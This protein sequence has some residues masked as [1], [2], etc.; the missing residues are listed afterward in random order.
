MPGHLNALSELCA[1][2]WRLSCQ[3]VLSALG[4]YSFDQLVV[5]Y[6]KVSI[7]D[8][9]PLITC[10]GL[11]LGEQVIDLTGICQLLYSDA[12]LERLSCVLN[13]ICLLVVALEEWSFGLSA[14]DNFVVDIQFV[15]LETLQL[16]ELSFNGVRWAVPEPLCH[17]RWI[18]LDLIIDI[19]KLPSRAVLMTTRVIFTTLYSLS[20]L[21]MQLF[22]H[23][24][25]V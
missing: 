14:I 2:S 10:R 8:V 17:C 24:R 6:F 19:Q 1:R 5:S 22:D 12:T 16:H 13:I 7:Q 23:L 4:S 11:R 9:V 21:L 25:L 18:D 15:D 20:S 3:H